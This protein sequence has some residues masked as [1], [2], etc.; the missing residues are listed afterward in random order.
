[1]QKIFLFVRIKD[2]KMNNL[3]RVKNVQFDCEYGVPSVGEF[4]NHFEGFRWFILILPAMFCAF[5]IWMYSSN[6][7]NLMRVAPKNM[8]SN[9]IWMV[10]IYPIASVCSLTALFVPRVYFFMDTISHFSFMIISYQLYR[11]IMIYIDGESG[12]ISIANKQA[13][14]LRSPPLCCCCPLGRSAI[15]K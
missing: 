4:F 3:T 5:I 6:I 2:N 8:K 15:S 10:S 9:C 14:T 7:Q 11:L 1:M 12:F 13:F